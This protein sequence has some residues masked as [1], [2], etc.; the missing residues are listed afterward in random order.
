VSA[1]VVAGAVAGFAIYTFGWRDGASEATPNRNEALLASSHA[2]V[3]RP[4]DVFKV[5]AIAT[6]CVVS[7]E[8]GSANVVCAHIPRARHQVYFYKD[9]LQVWRTGSPGRGP[10]FSARP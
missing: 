5:P 9:R 10:V 4:G 6:R 8:G 1:I 3:D 7:Q 2:Y